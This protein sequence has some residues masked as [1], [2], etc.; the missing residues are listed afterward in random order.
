MISAGLE[1]VAPL[2]A[3][4][5]ILQ[6]PFS[7]GLELHAAKERQHVQ[8][9]G[10]IDVVAEAH[11]GGDFGRGDR[12]EGDDQVK[13]DVVLLE[14]LGHFQSIVGAVGVADDDQRLVGGVVFILLNDGPAHLAPLVFLIDAGADAGV[15]DFFT[16]VVD[17]V[18]PNAN[19]APEQIDIASIGLVGGGLNSADIAGGHRRAA[20]NQSAKNAQGDEDGGSLHVV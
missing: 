19:E 16:D 20:C 6:I 18:G 5:H 13:C 3:D 7:L 11:V 8:Q 10:L 2:R 14:L 17:A 9:A 12:I 15:G 4:V 1:K